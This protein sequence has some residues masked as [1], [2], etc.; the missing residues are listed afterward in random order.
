MSQSPAVIKNVRIAAV[1]G[2]ALCIAATVTHLYLGTAAEY[3]TGALAGL[4]HLFDLVAAATLSFVILSI[5]HSLT[6][7]FSLQFVN[8]AEQ[9]AFSFFLGT[10]VIGLL[11]LFLGLLGL[12]RSWPILALLLLALALTAR[13]LPQLWQ[14]MIRAT[15]T[16]FQAKLVTVAFVGLFL[17]LVLR[18]L[19]PPHVADELIYHLPCHINLFRRSRLS[20]L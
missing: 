5:G 9:L 4:D 11:V 1:V 8:S 13:D 10:G 17:L 16:A 12:L 15:Q 14:S 7:R 2:A 19:T 20:V 3:A 18:T 6:K